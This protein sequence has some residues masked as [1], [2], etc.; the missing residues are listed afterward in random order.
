MG[1]DVRI[2]WSSEAVRQ[3]PPRRRCSRSNS[4]AS[5]CSSASASPRFHI[6]ESLI[7]ETYWVLKW[8]NMLPKIQQSHF[9]KKY[10]DGFSFGSFVRKHPKLKGSATD[11]PIGDLF[12]DRA[13]TVWGPLESMYL[14]DKLPIPPRGCRRA[15]RVGHPQSER[16]GA[17]RRTYTLAVSVAGEALHD[18]WCEASQCPTKRGSEDGC[19][20]QPATAKNGPRSVLL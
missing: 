18:Q 11:L 5:S 14:P 10:D 9:V 8:L 17:A 4:A 16:A 2:S 1:C 7:P 12:T 20:W 6:G 3:D 15:G 13:D 19:I